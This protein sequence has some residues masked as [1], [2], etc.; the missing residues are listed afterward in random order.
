MKGGFECPGYS[1]GP[2]KVYILLSDLWVDLL[3][4][5]RFK[6]KN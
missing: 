6:F 3:V 4:L 1:G 5:K 2:A